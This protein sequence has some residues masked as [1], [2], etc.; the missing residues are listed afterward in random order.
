MFLKITSNTFPFTWAE[1]RERERVSKIPKEQHVT[2]LANGVAIIAPD[3]MLLEWSLG[4]EHNQSE[5]VII[6]IMLPEKAFLGETITS[7]V[8]DCIDRSLLDLM[9]DCRE[10]QK[11]LST[12]IVA[13]VV[14]HGE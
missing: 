1:E 11:Q 7:L 13:H 4:L 12:G 6:A 9:L 8:S 3:M 2:N 10:E 14:V 5:L